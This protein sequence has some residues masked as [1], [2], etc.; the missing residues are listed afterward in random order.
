MEITI[1][2]L[3]DFSS[4]VT[5]VLNSL[6]A[7]LNPDI[8]TLTDKTAKEIIENKSIWLFAA[9]ESDSRKI[10][11]M[12]TLVICCL[13]EGKKS[14]L[15]DLVVDSQYRS[16]GIATKLINY[17]IGQAKTNGALSINLTSR[18]EREKA[19]KLYLRLGFEK[20]NTNVYRINLKN[21]EI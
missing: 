21:A 13:P 12:L 19:N 1:E 16:K 9:R 20:R 2:Q 4:D 11:G 14:W 3:K 15:E 10:V 8:K 18:P 7:Q 6:L 17:A 5:L